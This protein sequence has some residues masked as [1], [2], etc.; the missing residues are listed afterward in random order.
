MYKLPVF[1]TIGETYR[2]IGS[3]LSALVNY[4]MVPI[5]LNSLFA[6]LLTFSVI[7]QMGGLA[8][9]PG[10]DLDPDQIANLPRIID[11]SSPRDMVIIGLLIGVAYYGMYVLFAVAWHRRYLLGPEATSPREIFVWRRRHWRFLWKGILIFILGGIVVG[12]IASVLVGI[13]TAI[14][15][16]IGLGPSGPTSSILFGVIIFVVVGIPISLLACSVL[17]VFPA[18]AIDEKRIGVFE[19]FKLTRGNVWRIVFVFFIALYVPFTILSQGIAWL[20]ATPY[21]L[22]LWLGSVGLGFVVM[23]ITHTINYAGI[24]FGVSILSISYR[25]LIDNAPSTTAP[26]GPGTV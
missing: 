16:S 18:A 6:T 2:F 17:L 23:L 15:S 4:A 8:Y 11:L 24:A 10:V 14:I 7:A 26:A 12:L 25:R 5:I 1:A 9:V 20:I 22:E 13:L 19:S 21:S 3:Q